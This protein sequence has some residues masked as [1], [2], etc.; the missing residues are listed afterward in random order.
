MPCDRIELRSRTELRP[1]RSSS[2]S[3]D[4]KNQIRQKEIFA[5]I[6]CSSFGGILTDGEDQIVADRMEVVGET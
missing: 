4:L 1:L 3:Q 2:P 6:S 5:D